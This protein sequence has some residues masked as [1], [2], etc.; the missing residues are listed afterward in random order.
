MSESGTSVVEPEPEIE[1]EFLINEDS[2]SQPTNLSIPQPVNPIDEPASTPEVDTSFGSHLVD[3]SAPSSSSSGSGSS[4]EGSSG[5]DSEDNGG[6]DSSSSPSS[7]GRPHT[8]VIPGTIQ[9]AADSA[10]EGSS[11]SM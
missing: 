10:S 11:S 9:V 8:A 5:S 7:S 3:E 6:S 4:S 2:N 1:S